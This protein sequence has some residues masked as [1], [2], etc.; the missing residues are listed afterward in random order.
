[1]EEAISTKILVQL[2]IQKTMKLPNGEISRA[3]INSHPIY[4]STRYLHATHYS[5]QPL[6]TLFNILYILS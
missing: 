1:M 4:I 3:V 5:S 6:P 2:L